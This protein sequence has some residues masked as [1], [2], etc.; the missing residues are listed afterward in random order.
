MLVFNMSWRENTSANTWPSG[1]MPAGLVCVIVE[2]SVAPDDVAQLADDVDQVYAEIFK[3]VP[4][5]LFGTL[6]IKRDDRA[7]LA[8]VYFESTEALDAARP[9]IEGV[10]EAVGISPGATFTLTEYEVA[11]RRAGLEPCKLFP[12]SDETAAPDFS[13]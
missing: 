6:G 3:T 10:R 13:M 8:V 1:M 5:F 11:V 9:V 12:R 2:I 4:G 7:V